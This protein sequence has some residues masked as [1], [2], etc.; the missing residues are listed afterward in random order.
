MTDGGRNSPHARLR[1]VGQWWKDFPCRSLSGGRAGT[2]GAHARYA[3]GAMVEGFPLSQSECGTHRGRISPRCW[4][5][6]SVMWKDFPFKC[7]IVCRVDGGSRDSALLLA[8]H[9]LDIGAASQAGLDVPRTRRCRFPFPCP[10]PALPAPSRAVSG[11]PARSADQRVGQSIASA[12][13]GSIGHGPPCCQTSTAF[14][15]RRNVR[16]R[17]WWKDFP[18]PA[19]RG[20]PRQG[21]A[22]GCGP[23]AARQAGC[24]V[25]KIWIAFFHDCAY[26]GK[27]IL[28]VLSAPDSAAQPVAGE[29]LPQ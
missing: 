26:H 6:G 9:D 24:M 29:I 17:G 3:R 13:C 23:V 16:M 22:A 20:R 10:S 8:A 21:N 15:G 18:C 27:R 12:G 14:T 5:T 11:L 1:G 2:A 4:R 28:S 7:R 25:E 19:V